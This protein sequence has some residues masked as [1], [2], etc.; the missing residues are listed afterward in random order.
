M[1]LFHSTLLIDGLLLSL[2][3]FPLDLLV[4]SFETTVHFP[5]LL[6]RELVKHDLTLEDHQLI[7]QLNI[8][9]LKILDALSCRNVL[10]V[11]STE[12]DKGGVKLQGFLK[13]VRCQVV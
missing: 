6:C 7:A 11:L 12:S 3:K 1:N 5:Y 13:E 9:L 10:L 2:L 8:Q 4:L